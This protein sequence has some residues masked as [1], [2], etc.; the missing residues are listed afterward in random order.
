MDAHA[1]CI[2][3][4]LWKIR[5]IFLEFFDYLM[6]GAERPVLGY[7]SDQLAGSDKTYFRELGA[8]E[9]SGQ[10]LKLASEVR[11]EATR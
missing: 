6:E 11:S 4:I 2:K 3:T 8:N 5:S 1:P 7:L 10:H 9:V